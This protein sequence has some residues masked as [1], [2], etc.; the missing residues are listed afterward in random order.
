Q[1]F[2]TLVQWHLGWPPE[3]ALNGVRIF[4]SR[5]REDGFIAR[6]VP[7][8]PTHDHEHVKPFLAQIVMLCL[9][10]WPRDAQA[11]AFLA[12]P[13]L[14]RRLLA[15]LRYWTE[16]CDAGGA[17]SGLSVWESAPHT[18]MDNQHERAGW[19]RDRVSAGVDLNCY[20][21]RELRAMAELCTA[22]GDK[23][24][25]EAESLREQA[26][27]RAERVRDLLWDDELG[28]FFDGNAR[29]DEEVWCRSASRG[30]HGW[31]PK[32]DRLIRVSSV[33]GFA[34]L[35]AGVAEPAQ[36]R[37][38]VSE[39]LL[40]PLRF[41]SPAP[42]AVLARDEP[43]YNPRQ[44]PG[45]VG[46]N[47]R[48]NAWLPTNYMLIHGLRAYGFDAIAEVLRDRTRAYMGGP[49][50]REYYASETGA[51]CGLGPFW[52]WTLL[53]HFIPREDER[54]SELIRI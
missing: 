38:L 34:P 24:S 6:S 26:D 44:L 43:F 29:A 17:F 11:K 18:G 2:E 50:F 47:W 12:D 33:A 14:M 3:L 23:W 20:L 15:Y 46:C 8:T 22:A 13:E 16:E 7:S 1:Y 19:W 5:Q 25:A 10:G 4:L 35:W 54:L 27:R 21:V 53:A 37:R 42:V 28:F 40:E 41:W 39:H 31:R 32:A 36:A 9:R 52:G 45:D 48:A 51:G 30:S 49:E